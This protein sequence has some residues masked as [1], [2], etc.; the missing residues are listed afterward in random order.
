MIPKSQVGIQRRIEQRILGNDDPNHFQYDTDTR[1]THFNNDTIPGPKSLFDYELSG[2]THRYFRDRDYKY[3]M[4]K[5]NGG[6]MT[7]PEYLRQKKDELFALGLLQ[8]SMSKHPYLAVVPNGFI[9]ENIFE[10]GQQDL[11]K[12]EIIVVNGKQYQVQR[13]LLAQNLAQTEPSPTPQPIQVINQQ[14][15]FNPTR[16]KSV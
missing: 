14:R 4:V 6:A 2:D 7:E 3:A 9:R 8:E 5:K 11:D 10:L 12:P 13:Q 16:I 1:R 15:A